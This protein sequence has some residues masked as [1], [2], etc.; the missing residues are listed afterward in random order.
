M[1]F[2]YAG[3]KITIIPVYVDDILLIKSNAAFFNSISLSSQ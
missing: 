1:F 2:R 3:G